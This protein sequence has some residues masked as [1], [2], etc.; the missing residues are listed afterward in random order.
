M[1]IPLADFVWQ[2]QQF[3]FLVHTYHLGHTHLLVTCLYAHLPILYLSANKKFYI[4]FPYNITY[5]YVIITSAC[6]LAALLT[7]INTL[8]YSVLSE[9]S[10]AAVVV[11]SECCRRCSCSCRLSKRKINT[12][13]ELNHKWVHILL[14]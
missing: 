13:V 8:A 6:F 4:S 3:H 12:S 14:T 10:A 9:A 2:L 1:H 11:S 5:N 7:S